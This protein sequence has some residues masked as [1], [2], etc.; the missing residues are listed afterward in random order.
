MQKK[1]PKTYKNLYFDLDRTL[2]DFQLNSEQVLFELVNRYM[3]RIKSKFAE[4]LKYYYK[5]NE[6][7]WVDYRNGIITKEMLRT[8]R[9]FDT[10]KLMGID[11]QQ[12]SEKFSDDYIKKSPYK[13]GLFPY[14][15][16]TLKYLK[17]K[18]YRMFLLTNGFLEVQVIKIRESKLEPYFEKMITSEDAG[19]QK[20]HRKIFEYALKTV[21]AKKDESL[22]IGDD[23]END[24][25]GAKRFGI[26]TVFFNSK[27][28]VHQTQT[29]F[30][31]NVLNELKRFL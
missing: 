14:T 18:G 30:E 3:P 27:K 4:F 2:W 16:E 19:Y 28:I 20:P 7:L 5:V 11:G 10:F 24:I 31:I 17:G 15:I 23:L 6:K 8:K 22:M 25:F 29:T 13:T 26:D 1:P 9:F 12:V 21:N